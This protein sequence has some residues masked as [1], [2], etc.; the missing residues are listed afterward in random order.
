MMK[1]GHSQGFRSIM[2]DKVIQT[3]QV[4]LKS[5]W[6]GNY[7]YQDRREKGNNTRTKWFEESGIRI[8][9]PVTK[10]QELSKTIK[11]RWRK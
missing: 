11:K 10:S 7:I 1:A 3:Y 8:V 9:V 5:H 2:I 6:E 4:K